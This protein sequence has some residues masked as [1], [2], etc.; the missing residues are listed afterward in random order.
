MA[1][2]RRDE[3]GKFIPKSAPGTSKPGGAELLIDTTPLDGL[4]AVFLRAQNAPIHPLLDDIGQQ[5]EDAARRRITDTKVAPDGTPWAPWSAPYAKTRKGHHSL[6]SEEGDLADSMGHNVVG[7]LGMFGFAGQGV[8]V[9][10]NL[11]YAAAHLY[12]VPEQNLVARPFLDTDG[13]FTDPRDQAEV[14]DIITS[15]ISEL[16]TKQ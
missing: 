3:Q 8:D 16:L 12:G 1:G 6:L 2:P 7:S 9:G 4:F 13:A 5:Q 10:S 15:Y 11:E 14:G